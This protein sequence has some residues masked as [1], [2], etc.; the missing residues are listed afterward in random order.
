MH[1]M[2]SV[3]FVGLDDSNQP[4]ITA[5][6]LSDVV[7]LIGAAKADHGHEEL[8]SQ[9]SKLQAEVALLSNRITA[10]EQADAEPEEEPSGSILT[11]FS[12]STVRDKTWAMA[13]PPGNVHRVFQP[14][15]TN[16]AGQ[17]NELAIVEGGGKNGGNC[18]RVSSVPLVKN[19]AAHPDFWFMTRTTS[20][21]DNPSDDRMYLKPRDGKKAN[22]L[23][24]SLR[25]DD[26]YRAQAAALKFDG[27]ANAINLH[28]GTY[29]FDPGA[30]DGK[31]NTAETHNWHF[32]HT[33][34]IRHDVARDGWIDLV[35]S[36]FPATQRGWSSSAAVNNPCAI[37]GDYFDLL[38]ALYVAP[39]P[40]LYEGGVYYGPGMEIDKAHIY[41]D[42]ISTFWVDE[43]KPVDITLLDMAPLQPIRVK[44]GAKT[45]IRVR[46]TNVTDAPVTGKLR[47][48]M[49]PYASTYAL[50][51][52]QTNESVHG[53]TITLAAKASR[54]LLLSITP[55]QS[56]YGVQPH[57]IAITGG[58]MFL[59]TAEE[60]PGTVGRLKSKSDNRVESTDAYTGQWGLDYDICSVNIPL[61]IN[62]AISDHPP[63]ARGGQYYKGK[64]NTTLAGT[65]P[66]HSHYG[67]ALT[68]NLVSQ[69]SPASGVLSMATNGAFSFVP[70]PNYR[71][72]HFFRYKVSDGVQDSR[73]YGSW[74]HIA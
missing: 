25:F 73:V 38:T 69:D 17:Q 8:A 10:L 65:I 47:Y 51:D 42:E 22:R 16:T 72:K 14:R 27:K 41:V 34:F 5:C 50:V 40:Y 52:A 28:V 18:L 39:V 54:D 4:S 67:R 43:N 70:V 7:E 21:G 6:D 13:Q 58:I 15:W 45:D 35:L 26:G 62:Y 23:R 37:A 60:I 64:T 66:A 19:D 71:G 68:Y 24:I 2:A 49:R 3:W 59:P 48:R 55:N 12:D 9:I 44:V 63:F 31:S 53:A 61:E 32:Y 11:D 29:L 33:S 46:L 1:S 57:S 36:Q 56:M 20:T 30:I 74:I